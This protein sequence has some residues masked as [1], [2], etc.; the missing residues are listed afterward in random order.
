[1]R[2]AFPLVRPLAFRLLAGLLAA[3]FAVGAAGWV[4]AQNQKEE[5]EE[6]AKPPKKKAPPVEEEEDK[7]ARPRKVIKV[8]DDD[9]TPSKPRTHLQPPP[10]SEVQSSVAD[11][12]RDAKNPELRSLYADLNTPHDYLTVRSVNDEARTYAIE[13][14]AHYYSGEQPR[15][16]N[17]YIDVYSYDAEWHRSKSPTKYHSALRVQPYEEIVLEAVDALLKKDEARVGLTRAEMLKAAETVLA[18]ADR[19]HASAVQTGAHKGDEWRPLG[20]RLHERLFEVQLERLKTFAAA[21]DWDGATAYAR[22]LVQAYRD[23]EERAPI[24]GPLAAMIEKGL[25]GGASDE[26]LR[27]ARD[28]FRQLEDVFGGSQ[29][30]GVVARSLRSQAKRLLDEA[31]ALKDQAAARKRMDLAAEIY[32]SL[33]E[34]AEELARMDQDHPILRVG[35][36]DLPVKMVPGHAVTDADLRAVE[37]M[38]EGL[39]K[40]REAAGVGQE[41][42][43][44]LSGGAPRLVPLGREFRIAR[45][46]AWPDGS[47]VTVGDVKETLRYLKSHQHLGYSPMW[48]NMV[49]D[50]EGGGDSFRLSVRLRQGYLDPLSLMTFKV[51]PQA[52]TRAGADV[53]PGGSGPFKLLAQT[54]PGDKT[55]R[56]IAN[57]AYSSR[58][59]K[60]GL[61]RI[62]EIHLVQFAGGPDEADK[63]LKEG[64][65]DMLLDVGAKQA[66][67]LRQ[68]GRLE[69]RGPMPT[70]RVYFLALNNR[71]ARVEGNVALRRA[72]ALAI[73]RQALLDK[74]FRDEPGA[75]VHHSLNGPFPAG[76]W[77]CEPKRVP[78][79]LY[80]SE[81]AKAQARKAVEKTG[82]AVELTVKFPAGDPTTLAAVNALCEAVN[83]ELH[84]DDNVY[85]KLKP[86]AVEPHQLRRDVEGAHQ[87]EAAYYHYDFPSKAYWVAPLFDLAATD[88]N[89]SNYL[90]YIDAELQ[91]EFEKA[92]NHRDFR[93]VQAT[94]NR[95]HRLLVEKMPLVPLWQ[96]DTFVAYRPG[97]DLKDAAVD[98]LL[99]FNDVE[100]WKLEGKRN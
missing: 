38:Y 85:V 55:V 63:A 89:G 68:P 40:R 58:E 49:E 21:G 12:L 57:P 27:K 56:F 36:R 84:I 42:E 41:Y 91:T 15:F 30:L 79:E 24:A 13:P 50:A 100:K 43:P 25:P 39:V 48:N 6:T 97:V 90:G 26:Q 65:I 8:D 93:D 88:I 52:A 23:P 46:A 1:M 16:K 98:P 4:P 37:L 2:T 64:R 53:K 87:Y 28:R 17:G 74:V 10:E 19:Y 3:A 18:A 80:N 31:K 34:L 81:E 7:P 54:D 75:K 76:S 62:R 22:T 20:K 92:K 61:P 47:P 72:L 5:E 9:P 96:L 33:P 11:A 29:A 60:L 14:L 71:D 82:G 44:G 77:P 69:V 59:G 32:P 66:K 35:V 73:D 94:M 83:A 67:G 78:P 45:G 95:I 99:I 51:M 86:E 70:R